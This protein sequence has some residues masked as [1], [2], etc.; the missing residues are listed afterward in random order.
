MSPK[1]PLCS[2]NG[3]SAVSQ[4]A[5]NRHSSPL[6]PALIG[7]QLNFIYLKTKYRYNICSF[8]QRVGMFTYSSNLCSKILYIFFRDNSVWRISRF[9]LLFFGFFFV[10]F[11]FLFFFVELFVAFGLTEESSIMVSES[12]E[13]SVTVELDEMLSVPI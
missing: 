5:F 6:N 7:T 10:C 11:W 1:T 9:T 13:F 12:T 8:R 3:C 4:I 2:S